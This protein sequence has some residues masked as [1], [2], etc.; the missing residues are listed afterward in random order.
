MEFTTRKRGER[1]IVD[2]GHKYILTYTSSKNVEGW[3]CSNKK[4]TAKIFIQNRKI[5]KRHG[6]LQIFILFL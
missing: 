6:M 3:R 5:I 2:K 1:I 4:C